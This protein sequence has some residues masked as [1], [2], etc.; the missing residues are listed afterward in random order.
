MSFVFS[1]LGSRLTIAAFSAL[2]LSGCSG[3]DRI[4]LAD[5]GG[6]ARPGDQMIGKV[7]RTRD[8]RVLVGRVGDPQAE[9]AAYA[10]P[11]GQ[12]NA[13]SEGIDYLNTPNLAGNGAVQGASRMA[14][15]SSDAWAGQTM[16]A[17]AIPE[18]GVN[19]DG[20]LGVGVSDAS[21]ADAASPVGVQPQLVTQDGAMAIA[22]GNTSQ[23]VVDGIGFDEPTQIVTGPTGP[24][25]AVQETQVA[26]QMPDEGGILPLSADSGNS[27]MNDPGPVSSRR[28]A[29]SAP[30]RRAPAGKDCS[31]YLDKRNCR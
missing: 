31:L 19:I 29:A 2:L 20:E 25:P 1:S 28:V 12:Q 7:E 4:P 13:G 21:Y 8:G 9:A 26:E 15:A 18:G 17:M 27:G 23:P 16:S 3:S 5:V 30:P 24:Q 10:P 11:A 14:P 22:E 6:G